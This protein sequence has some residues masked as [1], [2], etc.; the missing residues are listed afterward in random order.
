MM[1]IALLARILYS[2]ITLYMLAILVA[3]LAAWIGI[4][5]E[6]GK[7]KILKKLTDPVLEAIRKALPPM[8]PFDMSPI[9]A[10]FGF[11]FVRTLSIRILVEMGV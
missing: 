3:W 6:Y 7:G 11:W 5:T 2:G 4:E 9:V 10:L 8:G 1:D